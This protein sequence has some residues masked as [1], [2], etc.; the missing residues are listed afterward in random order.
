MIAVGLAA[1]LISGVG[2]AQ[3]GAVTSKSYSNCTALHRSYPHG[4][5]RAG[6]RDHVR[7]S[8]APVTNFT[9]STRIYNQNR[10]MDRDGDSV[11]CEQ[12]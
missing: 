3:S 2:V 12:R 9:R 1:T 7:G 5:G 8:T 4:V 6:A 10:S 11:A